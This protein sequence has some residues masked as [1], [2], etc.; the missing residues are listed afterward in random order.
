MGVAVSKTW[1]PC[2][3]VGDVGPRFE[4]QPAVDAIGATRQ[5]LRGGRRVLD[6]GLDLRVLRLD[7]IARR[8]E[9][10]DADDREGPTGLRFRRHRLRL[11]L[12]VVDA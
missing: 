5:R 11:A 7:R 12:V 4:R 9:L 8:F 2:E 6:T 10:G 1:S 3:L